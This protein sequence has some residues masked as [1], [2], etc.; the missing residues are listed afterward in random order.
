MS[1]RTW[2]PEEAAAAARRLGSSLR[3]FGTARALGLPTHS[4]RDEAQVLLDWQARVRGFD[5]LGAPHHAAHDA[6][7][8]SALELLTEIRADAING[9][10][11]RL[12]H[13]DLHLGQLL[14][15]DAW[16][17]VLDL[18]TAALGDPALDVG[19]LVAHVDLEVVAGRCSAPVAEAF[20]AGLLER[21]ALDE[22]AVTAYRISARARLV[23]VHAFRPEA[24]RVVPALLALGVPR[25]G[26]GSL[27]DADHPGAAPV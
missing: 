22:R 10:S 18:D 11:S 16:L 5:V 8:S 20:T 24:A 17:G 3:A 27:R 15:A 12:L 6:L 25:S 4:A 9:V 14:S 19:N 7:V 26:K 1:I 23:A 13:R 21:L 2:E